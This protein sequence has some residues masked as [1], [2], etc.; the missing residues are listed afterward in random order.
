MTGD[1]DS[2]FT[3]DLQPA[4]VPNDRSANLGLVI[5]YPEMY[6]AVNKLIAAVRD[7]ANDEFDPLAPGMAPRPSD[8]ALLDAWMEF[9]QATLTQGGSDAR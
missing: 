9:E 8:D 6:V 5:L 3:M 1:Q 7:W 2:S 4:P